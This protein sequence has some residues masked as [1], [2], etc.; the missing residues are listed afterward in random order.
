M[1]RRGFLRATGLGVAAEAV[2]RKVGV[3]GSVGDAFRGYFGGNC[4]Q[5]AP[6]KH[7]IFTTYGPE[8][9]F[10]V[11]LYQ[12]DSGNAIEVDESLPPGE[13]LEG[14]TY[15]QFRDPCQVSTVNYSLDENKWEAVCTFTATWREDL[16]MALVLRMGYRL[17]DA[18]ILASM[19]CERCCNSLAY[20]VGLSWGYAEGSQEWKE[21]RTCCP[22]CNGTERWPV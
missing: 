10:P 6:P 19:S 13:Y 11:V 9:E 16:V 12:D 3:R 1:N 18:I 4:A 7:S 14:A 8:R 2:S 22:L 17:K 20:A 21:S 15:V 5:P